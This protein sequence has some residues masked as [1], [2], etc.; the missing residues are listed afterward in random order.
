[1]KYLE[2]LEP[3]ML[4]SFNS[5]YWILTSDFK[6]NGSRMCVSVTN[7][8]PSWISSNSSVEQ[9]DGYFL[10]NTN[11]LVRLRHNETTMDHYS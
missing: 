2:E 5:Q 7:G 6:N 8:F 9:I 1:M 11:N 3:G 10:D 4:F